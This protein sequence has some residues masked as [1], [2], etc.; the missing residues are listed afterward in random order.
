MEFP[1]S[2]CIIP[3]IFLIKKGDMNISHY[4]NGNFLF[5]IDDDASCKFETSLVI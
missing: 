3:P 5:G 2:L 4:I 1:F